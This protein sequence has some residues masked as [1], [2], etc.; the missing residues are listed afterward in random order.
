MKRPFVIYVFLLVSCMTMAQENA[1]KSVSDY[2]KYINRDGTFVQM[3][4]GALPHE[5]FQN[6]YASIY[7]DHKG[8]HNVIINNRGEIVKL[9]GDGTDLSKEGE[10]F[11]AK[12]G[13]LYGYMNGKTEWVIQ[14]QYEKAGVFDGEY[15]RVVQDGVQL[16]INKNND[17][18]LTQ[19]MIKEHRG[20]EIWITSPSDGIVTV[21]LTYELPAMK[22]QYYNLK[23]EAITDVI[24]GDITDFSDGLAMYQDGTQGRWKVIDTKGDLVESFPPSRFY[25]PSREGLVIQKTDSGMRYLDL[26]G[27]VVI[28]A[29]Y[30][31]VTPFREGFAAVSRN[32]RMGSGSLMYFNYTRRLREGRGSYQIIDRTGT[33]INDVYYLGVPKFFQG[34][35][36]KVNLLTEDG[37]QE[38]TALIDLK[39]GGRIFDIDEPYLFSRNYIIDETTTRYSPE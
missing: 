32:E 14:P 26:N 21:S 39:D 2:G 25:F 22:F 8:F 1:Y 13:S 37:R 29:G 34:G 31:F 5:D 28:D 33:P 36:A 27:N 6:G 19:D 17:V 12:E 30:S 11:F 23:G 18:I 38:Y 4:E 10:L 20:R 16:I 35:V 24:T 7:Y 15:A 9:P 3:P